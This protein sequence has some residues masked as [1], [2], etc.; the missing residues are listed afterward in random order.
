[1]SE[2]ESHVKTKQKTNKTK[3]ITIYNVNTI[4]RSRTRTRTNQRGKDQGAKESTDKSFPSFVGGK[5]NKGSFGQFTPKS[6]STRE[7]IQN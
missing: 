4:I 5:M 2:K 7:M 1:M 6:D 3:P